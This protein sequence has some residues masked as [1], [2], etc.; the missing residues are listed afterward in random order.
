MVVI[1]LSVF[2]IVSNILLLI[3]NEFK[4]INFYSPQNHQKCSGF[5]M[6]LRGIELINSNKFA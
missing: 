4:R 2:G 5:L 3:L 6:I 1:F